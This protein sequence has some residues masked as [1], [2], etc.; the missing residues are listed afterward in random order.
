MEKQLTIH[1]HCIL[2]I[3]ILS[4]H[5]LGY[6][7]SYLFVFNSMKLFPNVWFGEFQ[8][9]QK[10]TDERVEKRFKR[11]TKIHNTSHYRSS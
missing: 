11:R 4:D 3:G 1:V 5:I 9:L 10:N 8:A 2:V 6:Q 7:L